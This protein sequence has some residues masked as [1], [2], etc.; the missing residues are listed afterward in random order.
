MIPDLVAEVPCMRAC[1]VSGSRGVSCLSSS[2][3]WAYDIGDSVVLGG[4]NCRGSTV[5]TMALGVPSS[6]SRSSSEKL[7]QVV[8]GA[9]TSGMHVSGF[10]AQLQ[11]LNMRC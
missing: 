4:K 7:G 9:K 3:S 10:R 2:V 11:A 8:L 5:A 1:N 6:T